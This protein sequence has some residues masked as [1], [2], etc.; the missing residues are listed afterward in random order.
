MSTPGA[1]PVRLELT[2]DFVLVYTFGCENDPSSPFGRCMLTLYADGRLELDNRARG[3]ARAW[4]AAIDGRVLA[5]LITLLDSAG[6]PVVP[7]H[8][9]PPGAT[10]S[11]LVRTRGQQIQTPPTGF[12][13][14]RKMPGYG[15][16]YHLLDSLVVG[17]SDG[18]LKVVRDPL[19]GLVHGTAA[20]GPASA[21][22]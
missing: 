15:E 5:G 17:A 12:H 18:A 22:E 9:I 8:Q 3:Q 6:F 20:S 1:Q 7:P 16:V 21:A 2:A 11:L 10:R 14:A 19:T 4:A 13:A